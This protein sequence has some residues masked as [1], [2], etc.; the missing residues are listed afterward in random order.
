MF[1]SPDISP[2]CGIDI[3]GATHGSPASCSRFVLATKDVVG[4]TSAGACANPGQNIRSE[5]AKRTVGQI[6]TLDTGDIFMTIN[7]FHA[8]ESVLVHI[9]A[10]AR[11]YAPAP[12]GRGPGWPL[13]NIRARSRHRAPRAT[14]VMRV[15]FSVPKFK[16]K[17][18]WRAANQRLPRRDRSQFL[19]AFGRNRDSGQGQKLSGASV[20]TKCS[21]GVRP[22]TVR[23][24]SMMRCS[25]RLTP[26]TQWRRW[27]KVSGCTC[28]TSMRAID[29]NVLVRL[30]VGD[31]PDQ[32]E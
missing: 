28:E 1:P 30:I 16:R 32:V 9:L 26:P 22:N 8:N 13:Q 27:T 19:P 20:V 10:G 4:A 21:F 11:M 5:S 25:M 2:V 15:R 17:Q 12:E 23:R 18:L 3:V 31:A 24:T 6:A 14:P 29:T 7:K